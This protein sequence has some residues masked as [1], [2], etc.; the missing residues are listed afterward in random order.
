MPAVVKNYL[1]KGNFSEVNNIQNN[2]LNDYI[3]D[4]AKYSGATAESVKDS[5][6]L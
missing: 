2:I 6:S 4:M 5:C 3:A 1:A